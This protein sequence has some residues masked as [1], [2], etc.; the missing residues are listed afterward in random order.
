M[1]DEDGVDQAKR[2]ST[3]KGPVVRDADHWGVSAG[4]PISEAKIRAARGKSAIPKKSSSRN[5]PSNQGHAPGT[6]VN[7]AEVDARVKA[8]G[9]DTPD[10]RDQ[11]RRR[12]E[13][14]EA[15]RVRKNAQS[16]SVTS[17]AS[18][19]RK[20]GSAA[21]RPTTW[22]DWDKALNDKSLSPKQRGEL[23]EEWHRWPWSPEGEKAFKG[24]MAKD[25]AEADRTGD[26]IRRGQ[27]DAARELAQ[28]RS[29]KAAK[30]RQDRREM[31]PTADERP[32]KIVRPG[33]PDARTGPLSG[34]DSEAGRAYN[35]YQELRIEFRRANGRSA[36]AHEMSN[37]RRKAEHLAKQGYTA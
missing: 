20:E 36:D 34:N 35:I 19:A 2:S 23:M 10:E 37:L 11:N 21:P 28:A 17:K 3:G 32:S 24:Q 16:T 7:Q 29:D 14:E 8:A 30:A 1:K 25:K 33:H 22:D 9:G 5:R 12:I 6:Y 31:K 26:L 27:R 4:T 15:D 18:A 13:R